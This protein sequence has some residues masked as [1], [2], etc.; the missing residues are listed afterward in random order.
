[1]APTAAPVRL[2]LA[3]QT[4]PIELDLPA[5]DEQGPLTQDQIA[6]L[7]EIADYLDERMRLEYGPY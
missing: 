3:P 7:G 4:L 5:I 6:L 1:M 2:P